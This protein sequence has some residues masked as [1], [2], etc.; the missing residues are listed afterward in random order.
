MRKDAKEVIARADLISKILDRAEKQKENAPEVA[1]MLWK[2]MVNQK[3][4]SKPTRSEFYFSGVFA[5]LRK[6]VKTASSTG[7]FERRIY[8]LVLAIMTLQNPPSDQPEGATTCIWIAVELI[9]SVAEYKNALI[10]YSACMAG[11]KLE[12]LRLGAAQADGMF[13]DN[14]APTDIE[15]GTDCADKL[16]VLFRK[17]EDMENWAEA[18]KQC[19]EDPGYGGIY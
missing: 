19:K 18:L 12:N 5:G 8:A 11:P 17:M 3:M 15:V 7:R 13:L 4:A 9:L 10:D 6:G 14:E 2:E 1:V 16:N